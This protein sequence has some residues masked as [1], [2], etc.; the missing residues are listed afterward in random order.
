MGLCYNKKHNKALRCSNIKGLLITTNC[1]ELAMTASN[2]TRNIERGQTNTSLPFYGVGYN[3]RRKHKVT[4]R[5]KK[6]RAYVAWSHML[7]RCYC[8]KTHK[9]QP[10]YIGC[11]V[12]ERFYDFQDFADWFYGQEFNSA[13]YQLDKDLLVPDNKVYSPE[14]CCLIPKELNCL[15]LD[16]SASRGRYPQ[17][18]TFNK[19]TGRYQAR[20]WMSGKLQSLG[21]FDCPNKAYQA[22]KTTKEKYVKEKALE[23]RGEIAPNVFESLMNWKLG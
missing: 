16:S 5:G 20:L 18:V 17:G 1:K 3:S 2:N 10:T 22:Y 14:T 19:R 7:T 15:L 13:G 4:I 21:H 11:S 6:T 8:T 12:D 9:K 23:W